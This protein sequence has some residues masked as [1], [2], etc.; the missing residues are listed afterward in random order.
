MHL[1]SIDFIFPSIDVFETAFATVEG[2]RIKEV[3]ED[4]EFFIFKY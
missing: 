1:Q 3:E 2:M 4:R